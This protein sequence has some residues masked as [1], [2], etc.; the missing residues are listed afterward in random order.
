M[1]ASYERTLEIKMRYTKSKFMCL[2]VTLSVVAYAH[3]IKSIRTACFYRV[4]APH[5]FGKRPS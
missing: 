2:F 3:C 1:L 5:A 4:G